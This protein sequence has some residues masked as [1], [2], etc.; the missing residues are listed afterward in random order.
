MD[1]E[2]L[3]FEAVDGVAR[4]TLQRPEHANSLNR[5]LA[6]ELMRASI[7]CDDDASIRAVVLTGSGRLFC[8]GGDLRAFAAQGDALPSYIK[9]TTT[10][11][12]AAVSRFARMDAPLIAAVNGSAGGAGMSLVC[13]CDFALA[14]E[15]AKFTMAYTRIGLTPDGSSTFFLPRIVGVRRALDLALTNRVLSAEEA[16]EIG[17][18][19]RV[20]P[21]AELLTAADELAV[22]LAAGPT[23]AFGRT[24]QLL[25]AS[26]S[27]TLETQMEL[28]TRGIAA[29]AATADGREGIAAFLEKRPPR[30]RGE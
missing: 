12:H 24:K 27:E 20:V 22:R 9:E 4:I 26:L 29:A 23:A 5:E 17:L 8:G 7:R 11:L 16:L 15:S 30:F 6:Q 1:F 25:Y 10:Y 21:D 3:R 14:A 18:V 2:N 28:E 19:T 13:A